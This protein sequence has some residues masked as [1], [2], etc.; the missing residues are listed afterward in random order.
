M[1]RRDFLKHTG[2]A[3]A[4]SGVG[5]AFAAGPEADRVPQNTLFEQ[6]FHAAGAYSDPFNDVEFK[7]EITFPDG[8][9]QEFPGFWAG[10]DRFRF[11]F[12]SHLVGDFS[13]VTRASNPADTGLHGRRGSFRVVPYAG[14]NELLRH[15]PIRVAP[16]RRHFT[17]LDGK[18][19][20]WLGDTWWCGMT[21]R[22]RWPDEFKL[23]TEDRRQKGFNAIQFTLS[24]APS[25]TYF[26]PKN[27]NEAGLPWDE[28]T[29]RINPRYF[30]AADWRVFHLVDS[31]MVPVIVPCWG[32]YILRM[33]PENIRKLW[34]YVLARW[35]ALPVVWCLAGELSMPYYT[36][37]TPQDDG[38]RQIEA[39]SP[40]LAY[41]R[42]HNPHDH[43]I[44]VH[45][46]HAR[47]SKAEVKD[48]SL[49]DFDMLQAGHLYVHALP[50]ALSLLRNSRASEPVMPA[51][52]DEVAYEGIGETNWE[53]CQRQLYWASVLS[54]SPGYTYG[55][56][57]ITQFNSEEFPSFVQPQGQSWGEGVWRDAYQFRGS[58]QVGIG[59]KTL[60]QFEWWKLEPHP[61]WVPPAASASLRE[62]SAYAA[63]IPGKLRLIYFSA[64]SGTDLAVKELEPGVEYDA[65]FVTPSSGKR[66][67]LGK[68]KGDA[69]GTWTMKRTRRHDLLLV[70]TVA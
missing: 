70:M 7:A 43:L 36:S 22:L 6:T 54:G 37:P 2:A 13:Y 23:M 42:A 20:L 44:T 39:W 3:I 65:H 49:L 16:D 57:G 24:L 53:D 56:H 30:D 12:S 50:M 33:G 9:K 5:R 48:P 32:F 10:G 59:K 25:G 46:R 34:S 38:P 60:E 14:D 17:H 1:N 35:G 58:A 52:V 11:R 47:S 62:F 27:E 4:M 51:L 8:R 45:P 31:G 29:N 26:D 18:P 64:V 68:I 21:K 41:L 28:A 66:L 40:V 15:G 19:F 61:E 67:P 69:N 63:G 55:A